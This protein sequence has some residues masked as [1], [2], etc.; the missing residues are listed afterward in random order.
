MDLS[1][2]M[3][4]IWLVVAVGAFMHWDGKSGDAEMGQYARGDDL[5]VANQ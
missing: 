1:K 3:V 5:R 4:A 2:I